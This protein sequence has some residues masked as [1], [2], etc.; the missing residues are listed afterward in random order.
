MLSLGGVDVAQKG[1]EVVRL[2][3]L[4]RLK[5]SLVDK[6]LN[7]APPQRISPFVEDKPAEAELRRSVMAVSFIHYVV[8]LDVK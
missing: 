8:Q 1:L 2:P 6:P 3:A 5:R 7:E 4:G